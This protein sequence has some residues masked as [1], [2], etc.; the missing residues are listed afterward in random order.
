MRAVIYARVSLDKQ[1]D[2]SIEGQIK[3]CTEHCKYHGYN[4][5]DIYQ[6]KGSGTKTERPE[7]TRMMAEMDKWDICVAYKLDRFHRGAINTLLWGKELKE[8]GK[9]FTV[10]DI[11]G[12]DTSTP[13][14]TLILTM[15]ASIAEMEAAQTRERTVFGM[16]TIKN[17]GGKVGKPPYGYDS[18]F[19][20]TGNKDDKGVLEVNKEEADIVRVIFACRDK[21][22]S[23]RE[24]CA[25]LN[26]KGISTK[27]GL[28][29]WSTST[30]RDLL[31][32]EALYRG[33]YLDS[34]GKEREFEWGNII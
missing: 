23:N 8:Y 30:V 9:D 21:G 14:G 16:Q 24:I 5:V 6:E 34:D 26:N 7:Y 10:L 11:P 22:L 19:A 18:K 2:S 25:E 32:K 29:K 15:M 31:K 4:I 13:M 3:R 20:R 17:K 27:T 28:N 12:M 33:K 1:S